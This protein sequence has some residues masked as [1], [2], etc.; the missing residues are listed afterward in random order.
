MTVVRS[1]LYLTCCYGCC[2][3]FFF[4]AIKERGKSQVEKIW[5]TGGGGGGANTKQKSFLQ[6]CDTFFFSFWKMW[7]KFQSTTTKQFLF[8][9]PHNLLVKFNIIF[10]FVLFPETSRKSL[11][12]PQRKKT[13]FSFPDF[14]F[15]PF[16]MKME[17]ILA[18]FHASK[19]L[20]LH[21]H[22][23]RRKKKS[24]EEMGR[25][26]FSTTTCCIYLHIFF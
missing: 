4:N 14:R 24:W 7:Q 18:I 6:N 15:F 21:C 8:S 10:C 13:R 16:K 22:P 17:S 25:I 19:A 5:G 3:L 2:L 12:F 20:C 1:P 11:D 23:G 26:F 9:P